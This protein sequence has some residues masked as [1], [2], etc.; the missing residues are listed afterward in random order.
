MVE[1]IETLCKMEDAE[2]EASY[3]GICRTVDDFVVKD[4]A[5][6]AEQIFRILDRNGDGMLEEEEFVAGCMRDQELLAMLNNGGQ[7]I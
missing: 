3:Q 5:T 1:I 2:D 7:G 4:C 6:R